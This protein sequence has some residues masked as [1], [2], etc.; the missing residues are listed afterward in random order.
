VLGRGEGEGG[1]GAGEGGQGVEEGEDWI[2]REGP[3]WSPLVI[4]TN[5]NQTNSENEEL[6]SES[7]LTK[8][9]D[10]LQGIIN[11]D[12]GKE[13]AS[14]TQGTDPKSFIVCDTQVFLN[15]L[16]LVERSMKETGRT[17]LLPFAVKQ[18]LHKMKLRRNFGDR[19]SEALRWLEP[20]MDEER[21]PRGAKWTYLAVG[22]HQTEDE[23]AE[24]IRRYPG[25]VRGNTDRI[26]ASCR[27]LRK[28]GADVLLVTDQ[29]KL[30]GRVNGLLVMTAKELA[31]AQKKFATL[32]SIP[33]KFYK[34]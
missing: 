12:V 28:D 34:T 15:S 27:K 13:N 17:L 30:K 1:R 24:A 11:R 32:D 20:G 26:L 7:I 14:R 8:D 4:K 2:Y 10:D 9:D 3:V 29:L 31:T 6:T 19:A 16:N 22:V 23:E 5:P 21:P 25:V 33:L 18:E